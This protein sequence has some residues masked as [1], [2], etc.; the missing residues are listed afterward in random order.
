MRFKLDCIVTAGTPAT[1]AAKQATGTI[2]IVMGNVD[3]PVGQGFAA[4]LARPGGNITG[5]T[6]IA[7][8]LA[9]KRL[10]LLKETIPKLMRVAVLWTSGPPGSP[11]WEE[12]RR[13]A[14]ELG[15]EVHSMEIHDA[16]DLENAFT[17]AV[18]ARSAAVTV[19]A[20]PLLGSNQKRIADLATKHRLAVMWPFRQYVEAGGLMAYGPYLADLYRRAATHVDKILKGTKPAD[21]PIERPIRFELI[22]NLNAAKQIG[23][24]IPPNVLLRADKVIK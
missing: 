9:G 16:A 17:E 21:L 18:R 14:V 23:L 3:D 24:T 4:S 6:D 1:R 13:S 19:V 12:S 7:S 5:M 11:Q 10:E 2:P 20:A 8:E 15:L 22:I